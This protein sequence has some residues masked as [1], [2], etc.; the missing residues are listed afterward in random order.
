M[1]DISSLYGV[2]FPDAWCFENKVPPRLGWEA[3]AVY[4]SW[5]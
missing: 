4:H 1:F 3:A 5:W 2:C